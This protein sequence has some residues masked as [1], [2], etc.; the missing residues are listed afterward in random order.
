M[1]SIVTGVGLNVNIELKDGQIIELVLDSL[2]KNNFNNFITACNVSESVA[3]QNN[4]PVGVVSSNTLKLELKSTDKSLFPDNSLSPYY[5]KMDDTAVIKLTLNESGEDIP[6]GVYYVNKWYG[7][8]SSSTPYKVII[9][10]TDLLGIIGKNK[11][12][13]ITIKDDNGIKKYFI[14][15]LEALNKTNNVKN[16]VNFIDTDISFS[17]LPRMQFPN[18]DTTC[19]SNT[20]NMLS[21]STLTNIYLNR[22]NYLKTDYC[23]DD[24]QSESICILSDKINLTSVRADSGSL[25]NYNAIKV[26]YSLGV[27]NKTQG[28]SKLTGQTLVIGDNV[29]NGIKLADNM[30]KLDYIDIQVDGNS[31]IVIKDVDYNK[32]TLSLTINSMTDTYCDIIVYGRTLQNSNLYKEKSIGENGSTLQVA[33]QLLESDLIDKFIDNLAKLMVLKNKNLDVSGWLN[34]RL[35]VGDIV[36]V[37]AVESTGISG[38]YK[39]MSLNWGISSTIKCSCKLIKTGV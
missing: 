24:T 37:D 25:V 27:I 16:T 9:E 21:Q 7:S 4:N 19:M 33:N 35:K 14:A 26:L 38:L 8:V 17:Q 22:S 1:D 6:F 15:C 5:D 30:Y 3:M 10:A 34:P 11:T 32:D 39:I 23:C 12:P 2:G 31:P 29:F 36:T 28:I 13:N 20:L 18:L